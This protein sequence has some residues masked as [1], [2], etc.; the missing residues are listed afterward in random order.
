MQSVRSRIR[1][2]ADDPHLILSSAA[3]LRLKDLP[4]YDASELGAGEPSPCLAALAATWICNRD[5]H[6]SFYV[7]L[8]LGAR[9]SRAARR[10]GVEFVVDGAPFVSA[11]ATSQEA[12]PRGTGARLLLT[13]L[14]PP[15]P[16]LERESHDWTPDDRGQSMPCGQKVKAEEIIAE[17]REAEVELARGKKVPEAAKQIGVT[18]Q[19]Y[20]RWK[21]PRS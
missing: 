18:E 10:A 7:S 17:L 8:G 13:C 5:S 20:Y 1:A 9:I 15:D 19:T 14:F 6:G 3:W 11:P 16:V 21:K 4:L 12:A 2:T